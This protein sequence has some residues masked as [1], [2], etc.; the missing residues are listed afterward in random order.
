LV[1]DRCFL[2]VV[3]IVAVKLN[4]VGVHGEVY[5]VEVGRECFYGWGFI[6]V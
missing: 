3:M 2:R 5:A 6:T 4:V 1:I